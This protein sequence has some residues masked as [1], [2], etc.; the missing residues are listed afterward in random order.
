MKT[1]NMVPIRIRG[2]MVPFFRGD[3]TIAQKK[4][5]DL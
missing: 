2:N 3:M 1:F 5:T 4:G